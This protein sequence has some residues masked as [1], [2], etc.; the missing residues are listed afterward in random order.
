MTTT[1][2]VGAAAINATTTVV[3]I[4]F[5]ATK[6]VATGAM[7]VGEYAYDAANRPT[8]SSTAQSATPKVSA[9]ETP[10]P[11]ISTPYTE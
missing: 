3:G 7:A 5:D 11:A 2:I 9:I 4:T 10:Q 6:T 8:A 1:A